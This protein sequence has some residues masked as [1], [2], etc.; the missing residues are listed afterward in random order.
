MED[1]KVSILLLLGVG[2][3][4]IAVL[5][6]AGYFSVKQYLIDNPVPI[7][8]QNNNEE[9]QQVPTDPT[10]GWNEVRNNQMNFAFKYPNEFFDSGHE[11]SVRSTSCAYE[12]FSGPCPNLTEMVSGEANL[13]NISG[14]KTNINGTD[15]CLYQATQMTAGQVHY[16]DYYVAAESNSCL[17][18]TLETSQTNCSNY[19]PVDPQNTQ[20]DK[21]YNDC[22]TKNQNQPIILEQI[23]NTFT[24]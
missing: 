18:V 5:I 3:I 15:Y 11:P 20:Q 7:E 21:N 24:F 8:N 22:I 16:T 17:V 19:L 23:V 4:F 14:Q 13:Q 9:E 12:S 1:K 10:A 6:L 2:A